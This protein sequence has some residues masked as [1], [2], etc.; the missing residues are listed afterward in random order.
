MKK[1]FTDK[2]IDYDG[3]QLRSKWIADNF[4]IEDDAV[5]AF[6]GACDVR[7]EFMVDLEDLEAGAS[8]YSEEMLH[9][10]IEHLGV[11]L[12]ETVLRQR[13][14]ISLIKEALGKI[15]EQPIIRNGD[16]LYDGESKLTISIA[17]T[18]PSSGLIHAG[19]NIRSDNTPVKTKGL[20]DYQIE[21]RVFGLQVIKSYVDEEKMIEK[22][23]K[24]VKEVD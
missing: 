14:I 17:T 4:D 3:S 13:I 5:V 23:L 12:K 6:I 10:I 21:P 19:I 9:F 20:K 1:L 8:I 16:D 24:K 2:K 11:T 7:P 18:S 22:C 15:I